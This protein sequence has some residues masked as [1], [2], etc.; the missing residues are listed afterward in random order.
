MCKTITVSRQPMS[1]HMPQVRPSVRISLP[2]YCVRSLTILLL[3]LVV[4]LVEVNVKH[5]Q[6]AGCQARHQIPKTLT[7][8]LHD[9]AAQDHT[10]TQ[11]PV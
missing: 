3:V 1:D 5:Y 6:T 2:P 8:R 10:H 7:Q 9:T 11:T 4:P